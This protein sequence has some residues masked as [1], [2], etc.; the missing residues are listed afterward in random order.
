MDALSLAIALRLHRKPAGLPSDCIKINAIYNFTK[1]KC[2]AISQQYH[3]RLLTHTVFRFKEQH[4]DTFPLKPQTQRLHT[5]TEVSTT[6]CV[7][8]AVDLMGKRSA[9]IGQ[10]AF[11]ESFEEPRNFPFHWERMECG[12]VCFAWEKKIILS[13]IG[14]VI[15]ICT[16]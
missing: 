8:V 12:W 3:V 5:P 1:A 2:S 13:F 14:H 6:V 4:T 9:L 16:A 11:N 10:K 15:F 7:H